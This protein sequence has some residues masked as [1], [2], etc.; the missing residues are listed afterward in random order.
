MDSIYIEKVAEN[1]NTN[2]R[3]RK[4]IGYNFS[5]SRFQISIEGKILSFIL[6]NPNGLMINQGKIE[7][8]TFL[9]RYRNLFIKEIK[10]LNSDRILMFNLLKITVSGKVENYNLIVELTGKNSNVFFTDENGKI[11]FRAKKAQTS[12]REIETGKSYQP[13]PLEKKP[14]EEVK[15]GEVTPEGVEKNLYKYVAGLSPL[16]CKEIA[17][18]MKQ[19]M[20]LKEAYEKF[21]KKHKN[22]QEAFVYFKNGKPKILTTFKYDS[23]TELEFKSFEGK[24]SFINAWNFFTKENHKIESLEKTKR[25]LLKTLGRKK[26][27]IKKR[28]NQI[29]NPEKLLEEAQKLQ[30]QGELLKYN[31]HFIRCGKETVEVTDFEKGTAITIKID[32]SKTPQD[33][34]KTIFKKARRLKSRAEHE[35]KE[36]EKLERKLLWLKALEDKITENEDIKTLIEIKEILLPERKNKKEKQEAKPFREILLPSG[37]TLLIGKN[38]MENEILSLKVANPWDLWFHTREIP[39]SHVILRL[40]KNEI[41]EE[42]DIETAASAAVFYSKGRESGKV[43]VDFTRAENLKKPPGTPAGFIIYKNEKTILT[44]SEKFEKL[45]RNHLLRFQ[46]TGTDNPNT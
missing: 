36:K 14:F 27:F 46:N 2:F 45:L 31:L 35:K 10:N 40:E 8:K 29:K 7:N 13:P 32:P 1:L 44:T 16:N 19:G 41:P 18:Y 9:K 15:F 23:L 37:K 43:K 11:I 42:K 3:K 5:N 22:S 24:L 38:S 25:E 21:I 28:L 4:I 33:N 17:F 39:G 6:S 26:S 12:V 34:L 30:K 20:S